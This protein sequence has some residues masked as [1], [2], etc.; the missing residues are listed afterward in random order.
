MNQFVIAEVQVSDKPDWSKSK[1]SHWGYMRYY[2][3]E[4]YKEYPKSDRSIRYLKDIMVTTKIQGHQPI[5]GVYLSG[6]WSERDMRFATNDLDIV[7][8]MKFLCGKS[9]TMEDFNAKKMMAFMK[10][11]AKII[12]MEQTL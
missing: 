3:K 6:V 10:E 4:R 8:A 11:N 1:F 5:I 7:A 9:L 12:L 2:R